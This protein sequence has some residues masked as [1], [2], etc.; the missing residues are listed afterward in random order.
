MLATAPLPPRVRASV[1]DAWG[2]ARQIPGGRVVAG[3]TVEHVGFDTDPT[4]ANFDKIYGGLGAAL[5]V[6]AGAPVTHTWA[7]L[8]PGTPDG[9]PILGPVPGW[10]NVLVAAGHY[11]NGVLLSAITGELIAA[12]IVDGAAPMP[13]EELSVTR[14]P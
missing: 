7:R 4:P 6:F 1:I 3:G 8:R 5:P 10:R 14:F 11:R 12:L 2:G 13:I 9:L